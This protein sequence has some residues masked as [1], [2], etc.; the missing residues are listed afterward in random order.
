M[1]KKLIACTAAAAV[2]GTFAFAGTAVARDQIRIVGSST[3]YPFTTAVAEQFGKSGGG[4]TPVVES[5][6]TGGGM[7][8]FCAGVGEGHP[9]LTNASRAIKKGEYEDCQKNGV[10][11]IVEIKVGID[12][13][14]IAQSKAGAETK[15]TRQQVFQALAEQVPDKDG[16]L[17]PNPY[18]NWSDIDPSLPNVKIEVL[19]PPPTSGTRD[20]FHELFMEKGAEAF[21][22]LKDLKKADSKA[23]DK[24]WKSIRKDGAYVEAGEN[25][26]VIVQKLEANKDAYGVFGYS[27][28]EENTAK[29]RGVPIEGVEPE[30]DA[31]SAGKYKGARPLFV[32]VKKQ[33]VGVVPGIDKFVEEYVSEKAM[34]KDGYLARKGLVALPKE[35]ADKVRETALGM[36]TLSAELVN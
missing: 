15:L 6:G 7:K 31:I 16:K 21:P 28:L 17:I 12:G 2:V 23:F 19:G 35:E 18:K 13:L 3:V 29:L 1:S 32:Y 25:D 30:Y 36:K 27:F 22:S 10:K 14:T 20:S 5:T 26:N 9:D 11:D 24:V 34:S 4:K 8:L 33:H